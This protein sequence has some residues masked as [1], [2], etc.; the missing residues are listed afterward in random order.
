MTTLIT[1]NQLIEAQLMRS[2][3]AGSGVTAHIPDELTIEASGNVYGPALGGVR[4]QVED[5]DV[6]LAREI[7]AAL[8]PA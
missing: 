5:E 4:L 3:L 2:A 7:L 8:P 6:E 1:C